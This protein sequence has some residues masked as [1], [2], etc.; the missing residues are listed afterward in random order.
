MPSCEDLLIVEV[1]EKPCQCRSPGGLDENTAIVVRG[2][3]AEVI[4]QTYVMVY[5]NQRI[6]GPG[7]R[8]YMLQPG[9]KLNLNTREP[10]R[11]IEGLVKRPW[12]RP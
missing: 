3:T 2:D 10:S 11:R 4:G 6:L 7:G 9:D 8:F 5:D 1:W 12:P